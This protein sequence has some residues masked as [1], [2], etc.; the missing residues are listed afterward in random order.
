MSDL[1]NDIR[2]GCRMLVKS[3]GFTVVAVAL[4]YSSRIQMLR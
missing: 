3:P 4:N 2:Y 1:L